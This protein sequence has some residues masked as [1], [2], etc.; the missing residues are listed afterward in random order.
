VQSRFVITDNRT[1]GDAIEVG[2]V[3][4]TGI[5]ISQGRLAFGDFTVNAG[6]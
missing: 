2:L 4:S 1:G 3:G 5:A 6:S